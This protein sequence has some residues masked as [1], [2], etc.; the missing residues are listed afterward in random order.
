MSK[1]IINK[2][3]DNFSEFYSKLFHEDIEKAK[4]EIIIC[5]DPDNPSIYIK[6]NNGIVT[7]ITGGNNGGGSYDDTKIWE[8]VRKNTD[9]IQDLKNN[10]GGGESGDLTLPQDIIVAGLDGQFGAGNYKNNDV[11][12]A[13][14]NIYTIIQNI[15]SKELYPTSV[16][17]KK[18]TAT[19]KMYDLTLSLNE[20]G[21]IEVGT[22]VKLIKG[23]TNGSHVTTTPSTVTGMIYGYSLNNDDTKDSSNTSISKECTTSISDNIYT[24]SAIINEGFN[25]SNKTTPETKEG[26]GIASL[27]ETLIGCV[28]EGTN[29][30]TIN[31]IGASYNYQADKIDKV[32][33]CSNLGKTDESKYY[34][35]IDAVNSTTSKP[36]NSASATLTGSY[37]YFLG[38]SEKTNVNDF[39]SD[40]IRNLTTK[41]GWLN[42]DSNTIIIQNG[43]NITSNGKSVVIACPSKYKLKSINYSNQA[44]MLPKFTS[45][46][47]VSVKTGDINTEYNVYVYP[48]TNNASVEFTNVN[49]DKV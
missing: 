29:K 23:E 45:T 42:K 14:T 7:K 25:A 43:T 39:N 48:I 35:G 21:I 33:Y 26:D 2:H 15:L 10:A 22:A 13:G 34:A 17:G 6:D 18:A 31:A 20:S 9:A 41:T 4:G 12:P 1:A 37:Y 11:I 3:I 32:Y 19:A 36:T 28:S 8:Q 30:I 44:D 49:I 24:I 40:D 27:D 5:N 38:Y 46:G 16:N 47:T